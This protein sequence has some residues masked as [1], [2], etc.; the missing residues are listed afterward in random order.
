MHREDGNDAGM[1]ELGGGPGF[2]QETLPRR[3]LDGSF[4]RQQLDRHPAV[5]PQL[6]GEIHHPHAPA[7]QASFQ[8]VASGEGALEIR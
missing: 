3:G 8:H 2:A 4:G 6:A 1:G 5:Q 7:P